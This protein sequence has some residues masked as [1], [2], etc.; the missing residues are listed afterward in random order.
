[1]GNPYI[2]SVAQ[3]EIP[4]LAAKLSEKSLLW[5]SMENPY[6]AKGFP[7]KLCCNSYHHSSLVPLLFIAWIPT[8]FLNLQFLIY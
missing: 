8:S 5:H 2:G 3:W 1:M 6:Y 4:T 7:T